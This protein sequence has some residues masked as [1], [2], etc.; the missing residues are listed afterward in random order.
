MVIRNS[1]FKGRT[2]GIGQYNRDEAIEW[3]LTGPNLRATG[4]EWD[5]R[6]KRPYSSYDQFEFDIPTAA[7]GDCF[8]RCIVRMEEMRQSLRIIE[9]AA[10]NMPEGHYKSDHPLAVPPRKDKT[11]TDIETLIHH[12]LG[13]SWGLPLPAGEAFAAIEAPKGYTG[14]YIISDGR[15]GPY[16]LRIITP[17]FAHIQTLPLISRGFMLADLIS[18]LGSLDYVLADVDR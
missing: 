8:A 6:K 3:G 7:E 1:I 15:P 2:I 9:Q 11:M 16:R 13:V 18:I 4:M 14:Y 10:A 5:F 12:F 17:S